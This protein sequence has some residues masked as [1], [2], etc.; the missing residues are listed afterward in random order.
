MKKPKKP[1][2]P[3]KDCHNAV[4]IGIACGSETCWYWSPNGCMQG[5]FPHCL[6]DAGTVML[7]S[8]EI[9]R[10]AR[11]ELFHWEESPPE[12]FPHYTIEGDKQ[13]VEFVQNCT[14]LA[15]KKQAENKA[16]VAGSEK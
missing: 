3:V 10:L 13:L 6:I 5:E 16:K 2:K 4:H 8:D 1:K 11:T 9:V 12:D 14:A 7:S 15:F